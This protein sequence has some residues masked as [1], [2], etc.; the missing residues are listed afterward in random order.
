[1]PAN[2]EAGDFPPKRH[3][4]YGTRMDLQI[5]RGFRARHDVVLWLHN[6]H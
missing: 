4:D 2:A 6:R 1:M 5:L 3:A